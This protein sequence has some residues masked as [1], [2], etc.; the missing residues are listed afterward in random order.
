MINLFLSSAN[1]PNSSNRISDV[2]NFLADLKNENKLT[3]E[4]MQNTIQTG[5]LKLNNSES[6]EII[7]GKFVNAETFIKTVDTTVKK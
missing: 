3:N 7:T 1:F 4:Q 6:I 2:E 5:F